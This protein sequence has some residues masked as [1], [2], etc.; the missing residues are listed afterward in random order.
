M[1]EAAVVLA[2]D[3]EALPAK[4]EARRPDSCVQ[5]AAAV[6]D[7]SEVFVRVQAELGAGVCV[8]GEGG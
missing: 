8:Q 4:S 1:A 3:P 7:D 6:I 2:V 5:E